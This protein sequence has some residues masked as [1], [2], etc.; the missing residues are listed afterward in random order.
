VTAAASPA[1]TPSRARI[2]ALSIA[3]ALGFAVLGARAVQ[4]ALFRPVDQA[5]AAARSAAESAPAR[6]DILDRNGELLATSLVTHSLYADPRAV[7]DARET[8]IALRRVFPEMDLAQLEDRLSGD[9]Q[10]VWIRRNLTPRQRQAVFELG[11]PGLGFV[12]EDRRFYPR[13]TL[14]AHALGWVDRDGKGVAGVERGLETAIT[15]DGGATPVRLSIDARVQHVAESELAA[16]AIDQQ[17]ISGVAA[18]SD[19]ATGELVAIAS[20]PTFNPNAPGAAP[21]ENRANHASQSRYEMG[22]T[23]KI[24]AVAMGLEHG[25]ITPDTVYDAR[26]P[27]RIGRQVIRDFH[28]Q[29]RAMTIE[30]ILSH[31]S[32]I[33]TSKIAFDVGPERQQ[34]FLRKLGLMDRPVMELRDTIAPGLPRQWSQIVGA[35]VSFG[36][37]MSV[38]PIAAI[39]AFGAVANGGEFVEPTLR[40]RDPGEAF[41][42]TRV[43]SAETSRTMVGLLRHVVTDGTGGKA[44]APGYEVGG[45]TGTAEKISP[46][47]GYD[48]DRRLS[49]FVAVFPTSAPRYLV[50]VQLDEPKGSDATHGLGTAGWTAAPV[51]SR[52]IARTAPM[53]GVE[54]IRTLAEA[55]TPQNAARSVQ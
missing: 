9:G 49:S 34:A 16:M 13:G 6:A 51:V 24:F 36:H 40:A 33:G 42:R 28:A 12:E 53:L 32:N 15:A 35:T 30:E 45:K 27:L 48:S 22:S 37:G 47:G 8:A 54:P 18:V 19:I 55:G 4:I 10:F 38:S 21:V 26:Q 1:S 23:F 20:W 14:A 50:Y 17:A 46:T 3:F 5:S 39:G 43:M 52:I 41:Q 29:N 7:W 31:S 25:V 44:E 2:A 11:Q